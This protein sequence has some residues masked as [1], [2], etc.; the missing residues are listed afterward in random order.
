MTTPL[1]YIFTLGKSWQDGAERP[2]NYSGED[3]DSGPI[4]ICGNCGSR[5]V[6]VD[7]CY[8]RQC[9]GCRVYMYICGAKTIYYRKK[10]HIKDSH[11]DDRVPLTRPNTGDTFLRMVDELRKAVDPH[12]KKLSDMQAQ[13]DSLTRDVKELKDGVIEPTSGDVHNINRRIEIL[14]QKI[15]EAQPVEL[16]RWEFIKYLFMG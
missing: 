1:D 9:L 4:Y 13:L 8:L 6:S 14:A 16:T 3:T 10:P 5:F 11:T 7:N 15:A 12:S 2:I